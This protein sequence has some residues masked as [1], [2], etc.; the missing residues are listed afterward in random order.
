MPNGGA[1]CR[2]EMDC[3]DLV[4]RYAV[5]LQRQ[6]SSAAA[7]TSGSK[8]YRDDTAGHDSLFQ[9]FSMSLD[10]GLGN[11]TSESGFRSVPFFDELYQHCL[12][13][14][15]RLLNSHAAY[16]GGKPAVAVPETLSPASVLDAMSEVVPASESGQTPSY[17][18]PPVS[19]APMDWI[20]A[21]PPLRPQA[22]YG[23]ACRYSAQPSAYLQVASPAKRRRL[24]REPAQIFDAFSSYRN[25]SRS[26]EMDDALLSWS[27]E[28]ARRAG[29]GQFIQPSCT[30]DNWE[31]PLPKS[32]GSSPEPRGSL[33]SETASST[34]QILDCLHRWSSMLEIPGDATVMFAFHLW[35]R[36]SPHQSCSTLSVTTVLAGCFW[37]AMKI[38]EHRLSVP[39]ATAL[40][41][42]AKIS[43]RE[44]KRSEMAVMSWVDWAPLS[45]WGKAF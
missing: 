11:S 34:T 2:R 38:Q 8:R 24:E 19:H 13:Q 21:G 14:T 12:Q 30:R 7:D 1:C 17:A 5:A 27:Q 20:P 31:R 22:Y 33:V 35:S 4:S 36:V 43:R 16:A 26:T 41:N 10:S 39:S 40:A 23:V 45:K 37:L 29:C 18:T 25:E 15:E 42:V 32:V 28:M 9:R 3:S 6:R 44:L